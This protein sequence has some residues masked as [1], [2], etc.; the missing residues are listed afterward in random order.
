[1]LI[2]FYKLKNQA[3]ILGMLFLLCE[4]NGAPITPS[5]N[6]HP[7]YGVNQSKL[8]EFPIF[9]GDPGRAIANG[10]VWRYDSFQG[11]MTKP[12]N[13][14]TKLTYGMTESTSWANVDFDAVMGERD[15]LLTLINIDKD[16]DEFYPTRYPGAYGETSSNAFVVEGMFHDGKNAIGNK[17]ALSVVP[18]KTYNLEG[19][20]YSLTLDDPANNYHYNLGIGLDLN[21]SNDA[22]DG[23]ST[24]VAGGITVSNVP[25]ELYSEEHS[26]FNDQYLSSQYSAT[27]HELVLR[28]S[29]VADYDLTNG[30]I[31]WTDPDLARYFQPVVWGHRADETGSLNREMDLLYS[32]NSSF[33]ATSGGV[34]HTY[35]YDDNLSTYGYMPASDFHVDPD[36]II[37]MNYQGSLVKIS[38]TDSNHDLTGIMLYQEKANPAREIV[39]KMEDDDG[40]VIY[41]QGFSL[42][43]PT[44]VGGGQT[45]SNTVRASQPKYIT[46]PTSITKDVRSVEIFVTRTFHHFG[47]WTS[48]YTG[49]AG[50]TEIELFGDPT[51]IAQPNTVP[52][53]YFEA[54]GRY[55]DIGGTDVSVWNTSISNEMMDNGD[56]YYVTDGADGYYSSPIQGG[57]IKVD[58]YNRQTDSPIKSMRWQMGYSSYIQTTSQFMSIHD[59]WEQ[60]DEATPSEPTLWDI[61]LNLLLQILLFIVAIAIAIGIIAILVWAVSKLGTTIGLDAALI[62]GIATAG[63][64][65]GGLI[66]AL[67]ICDVILIFGFGIDVR[68]MSGTAFKNNYLARFTYDFVYDLDGT[69]A[70]FVMT[71]FGNGINLGNIYDINTLEWYGHEYTETGM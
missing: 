39:I 15:S 43:E 48:Q 10:N 54:L 34:N 64:F 19:M 2:E 56:D 26:S 51:S 58:L 50:L 1:M 41:N 69:I 33:I 38:F 6:I 40:N 31:D 5:W 44:R 11:D 20:T 9:G 35:L 27:D 42:P 37:L 63:K 46:F 55:P 60:L 52:Y 71:A 32:S 25:W 23:L 24:S 47:E 8:G 16:M 62:A 22:I 17:I 21:A 13:F 67:T 65:I 28:T 18:L 4:C 29:E 57:M 66:I 14:F 59:Y 36:K 7:D 68:Y 30:S 45:S 12:Q 53:E 49:N 61:L 70:R 3:E